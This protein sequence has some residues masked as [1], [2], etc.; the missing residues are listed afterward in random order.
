M[1]VTQLHEKTLYPTVRVRTDTAGGSG[2]IIMSKPKTKGCDTFILTN[3]HVV[4]DAI[5]YKKDW[6]SVVKREITKEF[7]EK[8]SVEIF[9]YVDTSTVD[10][11]NAYKA[12]IIA[13]DREHDLAILRLDSPRPVKYIANIIERDKI[14]KLI[15][16][17]VPIVGCGCSMLH[18]PFPTMGYVSYMKE[19]IDN[20]EYLMTSQNSI[21]GNSGGALYL[22]ETGQ[23]IGVTSR[24]PG[25]QLGFGVDMM[26]WMGFGAHPERIYRFFDEQELQ[27]LY[28]PTDTF[29]N[30]MKRRAEKK[31][32]AREM[33]TQG[34]KA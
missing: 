9:D 4:E 24:V 34:G 25:I 1:N 3:H 26:T 14:D 19:I 2:T 18:D 6:D 10:S 28:D 31:D 30:A 16:V 12:D 7:T 17:F 32:K 5:T 8:V 23:L 15:K 33:L 13:Y 22:T 27:F 20:K 21:F 11:S 29:E